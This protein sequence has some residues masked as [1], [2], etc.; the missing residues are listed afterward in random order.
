MDLRLRTYQNRLVLPQTGRLDRTVQR[1]VIAG[2]RH[3]DRD[4]A[5]ALRRTDQ[6]LVFVVLGLLYRVRHWLPPPWWA[7]QAWHRTALRCVPAG[8]RPHPA[9][10]R[11]RRA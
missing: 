9:T 7:W 11:S 3:S 6:P 10:R 1:H 8:G 5:L 2:M 4:R